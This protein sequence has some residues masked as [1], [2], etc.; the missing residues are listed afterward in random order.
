[1]NPNDDQN[2]PVPQSDSTPPVQV[3]EP[4][5]PI[6][7]EQPDAPQQPPA[8]S[9]QQSPDA[10]SSPMAAPQP[11]PQQPQPTFAP[12]PVAQP[13]TPQHPQSKG[14]AI[15]SLVLGI[16]GFLTGF[17]GI[18][19]LLGLIA[20]ILGTIS[21]VKHGGGKGFA[22]A[23]IITG[24][25]AFLFGGVLLAITLT[26]YSGIQD[27]ARSAANQVNANS[28][29]RSAEAFNAVSGPS[30]NP[31]SINNYPTYDELI[32]ATDEAKLEE[33]VASSLH[34]GDAASVSEAKPVAYQALCDEGAVVS[35][36]D[37]TTVS[38]KK[39]DIGSPASC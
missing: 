17:I 11:L 3:P 28:V 24:G 18:G 27:R 22:I 5:Q 39:I 25:I 21:L 15:A 16:L 9:Y 12:A 30:E 31:D 7:A 1:M 19:V 37:M 14:L 29:S 26:A 35:Y 32:N 23:G 10:A 20:V 4:E 33:G 8:P 34:E 13:M 6:P 38:A 36:W 2:Q